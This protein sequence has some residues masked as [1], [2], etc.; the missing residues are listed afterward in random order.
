MHPGEEPLPFPAFAI[1]AQ[2]A[3]IP[4]GAFAAAL[5][6]GDQLNAVFRGELSP[7]GSES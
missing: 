3:L 4:G 5:V 2:F 7:S 1:T 6:R